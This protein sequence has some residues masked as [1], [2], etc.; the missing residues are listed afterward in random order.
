MIEAAKQV[1]IPLYILK[2]RCGIH[3]PNVY[4][5]IVN[6]VT[7]SSFFLLFLSGVFYM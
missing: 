1:F 3:P 5:I 7:L 6:G 4:W 2:G